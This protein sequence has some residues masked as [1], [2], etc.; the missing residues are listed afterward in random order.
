MK[1]QNICVMGNENATS[2]EELIYQLKKIA[3]S[4]P[5]GYVFAR[6]PIF[7]EKRQRM[8][9]SAFLST[10]SANVGLFY[11]PISITLHD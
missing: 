9:N 8:E 4:I 2:S 3:I 10:T 6:K 7:Y 1:L 5:V 11:K